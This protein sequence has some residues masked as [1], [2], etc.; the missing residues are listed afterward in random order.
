LVSGVI[1]RARAAASRARRARSLFLTS[2]GRRQHARIES[3]F[4]GFLFRRVGI[5]LGGTSASAPALARAL[6]APAGVAH[7]RIV[8]GRGFLDFVAFHAALAF[9]TLGAIGIVALVAATWLFLAAV[10]FAILGHIVVR[11]ERL[12]AILIAAGRPALFLLRAA[13]GDDAEVV[14]G[15]LGIVLGEHAIA[16]ERSI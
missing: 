12:L 14:V 13:V 9:L 10:F 7:E 15:K 5:G 6:L 2:D 3:A 16:V 1:G 11:I 8:F 4:G